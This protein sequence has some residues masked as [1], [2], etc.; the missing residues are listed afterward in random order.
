MA[1]KD[2]QIYGFNSNDATELVRLIGKSGVFHRELEPELW[3]NQWLYRFELKDNFLGGEST[4]DIYEMTGQLLGENLAIKD[5]ELIFEE[6]DVGDRGYCVYQGEF[7]A[8]QAACPGDVPS[9]NSG[10]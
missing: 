9:S 6:L 7:Y 4:A 2:N 1:S 5:P 3:P 8:I 10:I